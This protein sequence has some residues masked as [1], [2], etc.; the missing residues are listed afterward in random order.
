MSYSQENGYTPKTFD[1]IMEDFRVGVNAQFGTTYTTDTFIGTGWYKYFYSI[2]QMVQQNEIKTSEV[3]LKVSEY[4]NL[5]NEAIQRPSVSNPGIVD[6]FKD[7]GWIASVKKNLLADAGTVSICVLVD[8]T[9]T[10]PTDPNYYPTKKLEINTYIK[11]FIAAGMISQGTETNSIVLSNGQSFDFKFYLPN[12][13]PVLLKLTCTMSVNNL[14]FVPNDETLRQT[15]FDNIASRYRLGWNFEPQRYF[16]LGDALWA[17]SVK[18]EW[19]SNGGTT[20]NS[21]IY[22]ADFKDLFTF[23]LSDIQVV[24]S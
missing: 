11:D 10:D 1:Q 13:I 24:I 2:A 4:I 22:T 3:F 20:W 16:T 6:S 9:I 15:V 23:A 19:S 14:L 21:T 12:K 7:K 17:G 18:L 8:N 5:K